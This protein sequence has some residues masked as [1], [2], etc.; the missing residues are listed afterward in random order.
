M[1]PKPPWSWAHLVVLMPGVVVCL[2]ASQTHASVC[3]VSWQQLNCMLALYQLASTHGH[4]IC[5]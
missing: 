4:C 3:C 1:R 2:Q 5:I